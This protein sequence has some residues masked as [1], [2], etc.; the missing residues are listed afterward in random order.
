MI[1][2]WCD[3][4][5]RSWVVCRDV[6]AGGGDWRGLDERLGADVLGDEFGVLTQAVARALDLDDDGVVKQSVEQ[7]RGDDGVSEDLAP[8][9]E[10]AIGS[11]DHG[12]LFV[13]GIDEL[14][15]QIAAAGDHRQVSDLVDDQQG[16]ATEEANL[17]TQSAFPFRPW[18][19]CRP[20]RRAW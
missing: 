11:Q 2:R 19:G 12:A 17:L 3:R 4:G 5:L 18:R 20:D 8:F 1:S 14:E 10:A 6:L 16:E 9:G 15:E 7:S 13:A